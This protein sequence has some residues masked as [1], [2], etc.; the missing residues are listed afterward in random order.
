MPDL[1]EAFA[2]LVG[3]A[4][5]NDP[6]ELVGRFGRERLIELDGLIVGLVHGDLGPGTTT[7]E[8][9]RRAFEDRAADVIVF[10]HSHQPLIE[11]SPDGS[12]LINPGSP[13]D[14]RRQPRFSWALLALDGGR[15]SA[16]LRFFDD[17]AP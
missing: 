7:P 9:A 12:L 8:R 13:T 2:P 3:V 17:R 10:G 6:P 16:E 14:K 15:A 11:R 5:N 1:L 4:G